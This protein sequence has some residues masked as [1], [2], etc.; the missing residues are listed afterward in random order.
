MF[1]HNSSIDVKIMLKKAYYKL[2]KSCQVEKRISVWNKDVVNLS[3]Y[4]NCN[5]I[6]D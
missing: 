3:N 5:F 1:L 2:I 6:V 4:I